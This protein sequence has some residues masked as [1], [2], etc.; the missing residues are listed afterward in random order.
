MKIELELSTLEFYVNETRRLIA[1]ALCWNESEY[2]EDMT[3]AER[4][5]AARKDLVKALSAVN[6]V[7]FHLDRDVSKALREESVK[8][9]TDRA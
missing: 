2:G 6:M 8:T 7:S 4:R 9:I 3:R 5:A 1:D